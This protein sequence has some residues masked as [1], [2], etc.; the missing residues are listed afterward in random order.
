MELIVLTADIVKVIGSYQPQAIFMS[1]L[2]Q[3]GIGFLFLRHAM[4]LYL[5]EKIILAKYIDVFPHQFISLIHIVL[6]DCPWYFSGDAGT[7]A[8]W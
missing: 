2:H 5:N 6:Q 4:I 1:Q 8:S 3:S 7:Q